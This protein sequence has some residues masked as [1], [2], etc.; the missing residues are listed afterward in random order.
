MTADVVIVIGIPIL[1]F[2]LTVLFA[3]HALRQ[4]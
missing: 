2:I 1:G 4:R 3:S